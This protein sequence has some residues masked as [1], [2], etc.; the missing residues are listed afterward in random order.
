L[1]ES[2]AIC[3]AEDEIRREVRVTW[4]EFEGSGYA[5]KDGD[6]RLICNDRGVFVGEFDEHWTD[7]GWW[8]IPD[9]KNYEIPLRGD[10]PTHF[11]AVPNPPAS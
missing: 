1:C 7:G 2:Y 3:F 6:Q 4:I 10:V 9:G 8:M 5:P 11:M